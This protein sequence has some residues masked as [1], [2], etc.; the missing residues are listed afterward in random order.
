MHGG[1]HNKILGVA[2]CSTDIATEDIWLPYAY[3]ISQGNI[4]ADR[5]TWLLFLLLTWHLTWN[6]FG[7]WYDNFFFGC[8]RGQHHPQP[9]LQWASIK[10]RPLIYQTFSSPLNSIRISLFQTIFK[11]SI[12]IQNNIQSLIFKEYTVP[13][14]QYS[15]P[16]YWLYQFKGHF[17]KNREI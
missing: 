5:P 9:I 1:Y 10:I 6:F 7:C 13:I 3:R 15:S 8:W 12:A 2:I 4:A 17:N 16:L 14:I 11:I